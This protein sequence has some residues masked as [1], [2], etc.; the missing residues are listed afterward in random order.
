MRKA[1]LKAL[2]GFC[3]VLLFSA[4]LY[5][6]SSNDSKSSHQSRVDLSPAD[7]ASRVLYR[8][9]PDYPENAKRGH[10]EGP[11]T[12]KILVDS[13]GTV[14]HMTPISGNPYLLMA[15]MNAV[16]QWRYRPYTVN[17][18]AVAFESSVTLKFAL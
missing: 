18:V 10:I 4:V 2:C 14:E 13:N 5:P 9:A 12:V 8:I 16:K 17:G 1:A 3:I 7:A 15:A 6:Q 11:V